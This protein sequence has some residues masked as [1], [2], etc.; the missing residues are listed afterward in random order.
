MREI[1]TIVADDEPLARE[2]LRSMLEG[3]EEI[4]VVSE[5]GDGIETVAALREY[6]PELLFLDIQMPGLDGFE[7]LEAFLPAPPAVVFCTAFDQYAV[8][9]FEMNAVDYLLKPFDETR[10]TQTV[11]RVRWRLGSGAVNDPGHLL[12]LLDEV[13]ARGRHR[14]RLVVKSEEGITFLPVREISWLEAQGKHTMAHTGGR[15]ILL[16]DGLSQ[17]EQQLDPHQFVRVN[18]S[19]IVSIRHVK[20]VQRWFKG[21]HLLILDD[22][23]Q[24]TTG[25]AFRDQVEQVLGIR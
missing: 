9:A 2:L 20:Q 21:E 10:L 8:R 4:S 6:K 16:K 22:G 13:R 7:V 17:I 15:S 1:R 23:T 24:V 5:C 14:D 12:K 25:R 3:F 11:E 19:A 18:R